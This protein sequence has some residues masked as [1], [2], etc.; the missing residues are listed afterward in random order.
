MRW[1]KKFLLYIFII[2]YR[3]GLENGKIDTLSQKTNY[4]NKKE[5]LN[6]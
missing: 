1:A 5:K 3:K 6:I 2:L 4:F